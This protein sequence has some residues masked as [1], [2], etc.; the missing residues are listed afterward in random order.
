[1]HRPRAPR[2]LVA[3]LLLAT[4]VGAA[5]AAPAPVRAAGVAPC[6][7][8]DTLTRYRK[9]N[10]WYRSVL[11]TELRLA[12]RYAPDDLVA[13][14]K[15][16][17]TGGGQVRRIVLK[18]LTAMARAAKRAGAP[19]AVTSAYRS[20]RTQV[21]TFARWVAEEGYDAALLA[22]ARPGHSEHQLGTTLDFRTP[23]GPEPWDVAD[24]GTTRAGRWLAKHGW[25][26]GFVMSY[27]REHS[28]KRTC[29]KYEPWH[30]RYVGRTIAEAVHDSGL[31][32]RQWLWRKG[33]TTDWTGPD[34]DGGPAPT[35]TPTPSPTP[36]P[37]PTAEPT[38]APTDTP[39]PTDAPDPQPTST[40]EPE[41]TD[42]PTPEPTDA[43]TP[44]P[45]P[46][47]EREPEPT[48]APDPT[49][50]PEPTPEPAG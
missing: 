25:K 32:L 24:W 48:D 4:V 16:G 39:D 15:A 11:D 7:V 40:A 13:V 33:G 42:A 19:L 30:Y 34:P 10:D 37:D 27:P 9:V 31:S 17:L 20:Y 21:S 18:D 6:T 36:S 1:M 12:S 44:D 29:Y 43:P 38:P 47:P 49:D 50:A 14:S 45:D 35:P 22:S 3:A 41:P 8:G 5:G 28:P 2:P 23:G 26:Y 46:E